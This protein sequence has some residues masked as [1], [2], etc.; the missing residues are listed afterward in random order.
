VRAGSERG[1]GSASGGAYLGAVVEGSLS[2]PLGGSWPGGACCGP[3]PRGS[4]GH[5][6]V[7][8]SGAGT[9]GG[10]GPALL[11]PALGV[12]GSLPLVPNAGVL[13]ARPSRSAP[14]PP[15]WGYRGIFWLGL[16]TNAVTKR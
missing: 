2:L 9:R 4:R 14:A 3:L 12:P 6:R 8:H 16:V 7:H 11:S 1:V 15:V 5:R 13:V 10:L